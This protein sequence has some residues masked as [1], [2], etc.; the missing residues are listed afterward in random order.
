MKSSVSDTDAYRTVCREAA[1]DDAKLAVFKSIHAYRCI[2][3]HASHTVGQVCLDYITKHAPE[4]LPLLPKFKENDSLGNPGVCGYANGTFSP[5]TLRYI[6]VLAELKMLFGPLD[7][8]SI[9]EVGCGYGGQAKIIQDAYPSVTHEI[10]DLPEAEALTLRYAR[11]FGFK[12]SGYSGA[13]PIDLFLSN[14][15]FTE[16]SVDLQRGHLKSIIPHCKRGYITCNFLSGSYGVESL[17]LGSVV[18][19]IRAVG[20]DVEL[21][22]EV[23]LTYGGNIILVWGRT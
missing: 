19:A 14:Y 9:V 11:H 7:N 10:V 17:S 5:T 20:H 23:P 4:L 6:K 13:Q 18:D 12:C 22:R 16:L 3:E 1:T 15:A 8:F 21:I 2:L